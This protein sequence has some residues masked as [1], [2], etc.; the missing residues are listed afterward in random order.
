MR[1]EKG[2]WQKPGFLEK[3]GF[4]VGKTGFI[5]SHFWIIFIFTSKKIFY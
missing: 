2:S 5:N 1:C 3:P 4:L